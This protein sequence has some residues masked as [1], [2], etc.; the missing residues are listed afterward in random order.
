MGATPAERRVKR[1]CAR[2]EPRYEARIRAVHVWHLKQIG[3]GTQ[4]G[5]QD[6]RRD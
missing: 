4:W 1:Q 5:A 2:N 6:A 3:E